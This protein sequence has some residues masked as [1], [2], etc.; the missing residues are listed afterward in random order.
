MGDMRLF[1]LV[2]GGAHELPEQP[3][4]QERELQQRFEQHLRALT[5]ID[6]LASEY[7]TGA[8]HKRRIDTLGLDEEGRPVVIEYKRRR[9]DNVINQGLDYLDWLDDHQAEIRE[10]VRS[11]LGRERAQ[12]MDFGQARL[13]CIAADFP[14]QDVVAARDSRRR[15]ELL[16]YRRY[17]E[18]YLALEWV[19]GGE[20]ARAAPVRNRADRAPAASTA[21]AGQAM[22]F[23][24]N[25]GWQRAGEEVRALFRELQAFVESLREDVYPEAAWWGIVFRPQKGNGKKSRS[26]LVEARIGKRFITVYVLEK[27]QSAPLEKDF[28]T[29]VKGG[30]MRK[31]RIHDRADL[32]RAKPL[33]RDACLNR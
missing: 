14:R 27:T 2:Y 19:Y 25:E 3:F 17:G 7:S 6:F 16:R 8:R 20:E 24:V 29:A 21:T 22:D 28:T 4:P 11:T 30:R 15:I 10:L 12:G 1:H 9:D 33:L 5:G 26:V 18:D 32:E 31:M 13:L 23:T